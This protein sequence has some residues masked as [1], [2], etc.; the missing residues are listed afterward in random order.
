MHC[1]PP[2]LPFMVEYTSAGTQ[3]TLLPDR[4]RATS[5][6]DS[7]S[8]YGVPVVPSSQSLLS[9]CNLCAV[10]G[11]LSP[12]L[13]R[14]SFLKVCSVLVVVFAFHH[15][16]LAVASVRPS[17]EIPVCVHVCTLVSAFHTAVMSVP[18]PSKEL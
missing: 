11:L 4:S 9:F 16:M 14:I 8:L 17:S 5:K 10:L 3:A 18:L 12:D 6:S 7:R 1:V 15:W 13:E 2:G